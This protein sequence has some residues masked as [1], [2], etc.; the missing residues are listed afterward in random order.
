[1]EGRQTIGGTNAPLF[2]KAG[3]GTWFVSDGGRVFGPI[4]WNEVKRMGESGT[5]SPYAFVREENWSQWAPISWYFRVKTKSDLEMEGLLPSR[6]D[7][8]FWLGVSAFM[9]GIIFLFVS[10]FV[11]FLLVSA[12]PIIEFYALYLE[13]KHKEKAITRTIG[14]A[15]AI[16]WIVIQVFLTGVMFYA[17]I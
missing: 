11:G 13:S 4:S 6:Y 12:S 14:N 1:M 7:A 15:I 9:I 5:I 16:L 10:L 17:V 2:P 8:L 3:E